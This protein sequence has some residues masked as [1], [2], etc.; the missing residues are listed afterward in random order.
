V[1]VTNLL[2]STPG[3]YPVFLL[4]TQIGSG[5]YGSAGAGSGQGRPSS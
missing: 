4:P 3:I 1:D 2:Q 5:V